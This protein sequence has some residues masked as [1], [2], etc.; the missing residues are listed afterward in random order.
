MNHTENLEYLAEVPELTDA[1][2]D[3][4]AMFINEGCDAFF[5]RSGC[6]PYDAF[7]IAGRAWEHGWMQACRDDRD[8][9]AM[10]VY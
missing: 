8:A 7:S 1:Q 10:G 2:M 6:C 9:R 3:P 4:C 5:S